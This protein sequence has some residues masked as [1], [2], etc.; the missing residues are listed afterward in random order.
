M[1]ADGDITH[2]E[3]EAMLDE[4]SR[5]G[6][7]LMVSLAFAQFLF[8]LASADSSATQT[9]SCWL[10][11]TCVDDVPALR[12][13]AMRMRGRYALKGLGDTVAQSAVVTCQRRRRWASLG[14]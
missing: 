2:R 12:S 7:R 11:S 9:S 6:R 13:R 3:A 5:R 8:A 10:G 4:L 1:I 14:L